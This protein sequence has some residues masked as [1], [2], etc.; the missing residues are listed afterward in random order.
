MTSAV[1]LCKLTLVALV[2]FGSI[3]HV[4]AHSLANL[5]RIPDV[6]KGGSLLA[7]RPQ[8]V[9]FVHLPKCAGTTVGAVFHMH[10]WSRTLWSLTQ[11]WSGWKANRLLHSIH[12]LLSRNLTKIFV[13]WHLD[14]N[15]S[16]VSEIAQYVR[17]MRP[18]VV[19]RSF[20]ILR[21]P[22]ELVGSNGAYWA[23]EMA[24]PLFIDQHPEM[25]LFGSIRI[26]STIADG[27]GECAK[28]R[29]FCNA[30]ARYYARIRGSR[31]INVKDEVA[32][33]DAMAQ[34]T[35]RLTRL[36]VDGC[37]S[38]IEEAIHLLSSVDRVLLLED[39]TTMRVVHAMARGDLSFRPLRPDIKLIEPSQRNTATVGSK[40]RAPYRTAD[41][42][43]LANTANNC[44]MTLYR[45]LQHGHDAFSKR[46]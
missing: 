22:I 38:L 46:G 17:R 16:A 32:A 11:R 34:R 23:P 31:S 41:A 36:A 8:V 43:A 24:A 33:E 28:N 30:I 3:P 45:R 19:F 44:S 39:E 14:Y 27:R 40:Q 5:G 35:G 10:N 29:T 6:A 25:L 42:I 9:L 20:T 4:F 18:G 21:S 2:A 26:K 13:E 12:W 15:F 7:A 1:S 37:N